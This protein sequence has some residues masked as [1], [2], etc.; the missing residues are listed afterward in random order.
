M[1]GGTA[2]KNHLTEEKQHRLKLSLQSTVY[3]L[4]SAKLMHGFGASTKLEV[5]RQGRKN[6]SPTT[7]QGHAS[8]PTCSGI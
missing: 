8:F 2:D 5:D 6:P 1:N 3:V 7:T 4:H